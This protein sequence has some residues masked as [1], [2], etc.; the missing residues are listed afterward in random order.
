MKQ[1]V[2]LAGLGLTAMLLLAGCQTNQHMYQWGNYEET[3]FTYFHEPAVKDEMLEK[4]LDFLA[5]S[6]RDSKRV[7]PGLFA[8]AGTFLFEAGDFEGAIR[9][10][11]L[12]AKLWPQSRPLMETLIASILRIQGHQQDQEVAL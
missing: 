10:Y 12:E 4:Y 11:E 7:A 6:S 5:R 8:E 2:K 1:S 3:L 9:F